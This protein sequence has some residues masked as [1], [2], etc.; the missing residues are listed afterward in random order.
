MSNTDTAKNYESKIIGGKVAYW[1][2]KENAVEKSFLQAFDEFQ[3]MVEKNSITRL[4]VAVEMHDPW[5]KQIQDIWIKT[6]EIADKA[7]IKKWGIY[8]PE[9]NFKK[10]TI[11]FLVNGGG[12]G[13][14]SYEHFIS[15]D[16][17]DVINWALK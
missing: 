14:R 13:T 2:F 10:P 12:R 15:S 1:K 6:G 7:G 8:V 9:E 11:R 5:G 17:R 4:V 16:E 3:T